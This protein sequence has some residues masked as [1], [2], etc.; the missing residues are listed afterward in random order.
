M[1]VYYGSGSGFAEQPDVTVADGTFQRRFGATLPVF[2]QLNE[3]GDLSVAIG[4]PQESG[5]DVDGAVYIWF[6]SPEDGD[7]P[8]DADLVIGDSNNG[9]FGGLNNSD[10]G[11]LNADGHLDLAFGVPSQ[12]EVD[13]FFGPFGAGV[14]LDVADADV[15][16][17]SSSGGDFGSDL[18]T[19]DLDGDGYQDVLISDVDGPGA[20]HL[21]VGGSGFSG[22][23]SASDAATVIGG[24]SG[25]RGIGTFAEV[26]DSD[27]NGVDD[28][29]VGSSEG[30]GYGALFYGP[31]GTRS[32][33]DQA[34]AE[35]AGF[36]DQGCFEFAALTD[37]NG[38]ASADLVISCSLPFPGSTY[39]VLGRGE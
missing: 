16:V 7:Q 32:S 37:T 1:F 23:Y 11:D 2:G 29:L 33:V 39:I 5:Q 35:F 10:S 22:N 38:D 24:S 12:D 28:L 27:G 34:D 21:F 36:E 17:A 3:G 18:A 14:N 26:A 6:G 4:A 15:R 19:G 9:A 8:T 13:V 25:D 31:L 30:D 20:V